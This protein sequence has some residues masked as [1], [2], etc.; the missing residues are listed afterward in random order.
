MP[1]ELSDALRAWMNREILLENPQEKELVAQGS[2][3]S[4]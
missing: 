2:R 4:D 3:L 1:D